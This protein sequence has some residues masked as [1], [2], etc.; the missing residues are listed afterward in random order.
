MNDFIS[1]LKVNIRE[2]T[3]HLRFVINKTDDLHS[4]IL[5]FDLKKQIRTSEELAHMTHLLMQAGQKHKQHFITVYA[6]M[7]TESVDKCIEDNST[8]IELKSLF[9]TLRALKDDLLI[10]SKRIIESNDDAKA[11]VDKTMNE[12]GVQKPRLNSNKLKKTFYGR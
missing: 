5:L 11:F 10:K 3:E 2:V 4:S 12:M 8:D 7:N 6:E 9:T 1:T